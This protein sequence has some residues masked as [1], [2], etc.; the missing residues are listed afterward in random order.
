MMNRLNWI[1]QEQKVADY[2]VLTW[3]TSHFHKP[4]RTVIGGAAA[5]KPESGVAAASGAQRQADGIG[6]GLSDK[7]R[8]GEWKTGGL[9]VDGLSEDGSKSARDNVRLSA[10][11]REA[12]HQSQG[13]TAQ[14][15][16]VQQILPDGIHATVSSIRQSLMR[17]RGRIRQSTAVFRGLYKNKPGQ[18]GGNSV[19]Q[20]AY[21]NPS[22]KENQGTRK[23]N[24]EQ[25]LS[26]QAENHYL[27]D[28]Y[29]KNG[30]YNMLGKS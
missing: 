25:V 17:L 11:G 9:G 20:G 1:Q 8:G 29:D 3:R 24:K 23:A 21:R 5:M 13:M 16:T 10:S 15:K 26:M 4:N 28:S 12:G 6:F 7:I 22:G 18:A 2:H 30:Q 19:K 27:L 14:Q